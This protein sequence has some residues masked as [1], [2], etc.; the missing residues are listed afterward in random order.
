MQL[1]MA[2][3]DSA[4][5]TTGTGTAYNFDASTQSLQLGGGRQSKVY[6]FGGTSQLWF[7]AQPILQSLDLGDV[8]SAL[9]QLRKC[10]RSSLEKLMEHFGAPIGA[11]DMAAG[12]LSEVFITEAGIYDVTA[13][14]TQPGAK[15]FKYRMLDDILPSIRACVVR[16][17]LS[18]SKRSSA[19]LQQGEDQG[20]GKRLRTEEQQLAM[21]PQ[22]LHERL[23]LIPELQREVQ[24]LRQQ[25]A[26]LPQQV[27]FY[28]SQQLKDLHDAMMSPTGSFVSALRHVMPRDTTKYPDDQHATPEQLHQCEDVEQALQNELAH[29]L[30]CRV[31]TT[32]R[33][34]LGKSLKRQRR[35]DEA[36]EQ[37]LLWANE[38][39][40]E[41]TGQHYVYTQAQLQ[42]Y[43]PRALAVEVLVQVS[44]AGHVVTSYNPHNNMQGRPRKAKMTRR[45]WI[46]RLLVEEKQCGLEPLA[47]PK[48]QRS[49]PNRQTQA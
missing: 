49:L 4:A 33:G 42:E 24:E 16:K 26:H 45:A 19:V 17:T 3:S 2:L 20:H 29:T 48:N 5:C 22:H 18:D 30:S 31:W 13:V 9:E 37:K 34:A 11:S 21:I 7:E 36:C 47:W 40:H 46:E 41:C 38:S 25:V 32:V 1:V 43:L 23:A 10:D 15:D 12:G 35:L 28:Q 44:G 14:S 6:A 27:T 39:E 8:T